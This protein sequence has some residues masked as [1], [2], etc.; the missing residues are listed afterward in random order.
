RRATG[1]RRRSACT[2]SAS[3]PTRACRRHAA[4]GSGRCRWSSSGGAGAVPRPGASSST[5]RATGSTSPRPPGGPGTSATRARAASR[6]GRGRRSGPQPERLRGAAAPGEADPTRRRRAALV[7]LLG[8][9][10]GAPAVLAEARRRLDAY[11]AARSA[12]EPNLAD[13][14]VALAA[15]VGDEALYDRYRAAVAAA[16]TPQERRRFLLGLGSF[17][18][19]A[20]REQTLAAVLMPEIPTQDVA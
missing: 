15:R 17:R 11:P 7:R 8:G 3:S 4:G 6:A 19:R 9:V 18:T 20:A 16:A 2:R 5:R 10:A 1:V 12:L 13:P 14:V